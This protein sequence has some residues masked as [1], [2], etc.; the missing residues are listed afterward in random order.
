MIKHIIYDR[1][2]TNMDEA[3]VY[4]RC[5]PNMDEGFASVQN[6]VTIEHERWIMRSY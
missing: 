6:M 5:M 4:D 2:M 1:C 3:F